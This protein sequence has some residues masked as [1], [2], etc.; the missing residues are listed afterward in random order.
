MARWVPGLRPKIEISLNVMIQHGFNI[1]VSSL[2]PSVQH[3][4]SVQYSLMSFIVIYHCL[5][6]L[7]KI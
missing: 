4:V 6:E 1:R 3:M 2:K 5:R 7:P